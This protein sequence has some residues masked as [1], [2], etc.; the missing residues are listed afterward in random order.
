MGLVALKYEFEYLTDLK[1]TAANARYFL[2]SIRLP[3]WGYDFR[4][5]RS[6][7]SLVDTISEYLKNNKQSE[8][9]EE[10]KEE[11]V[12]PS[13]DEST[14]LE[15]E[16][17]VKYK[18]LLPNWKIVKRTEGINSIKNFKRVKRSISLWLHP[19]RNKDPSATKYMSLFNNI[20]DLIKK[21]LSK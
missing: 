20:F 17:I 16:V 5:I 13:D 7:S 21:T 9:Q 10:V 2:S 15:K 4:T 19:D 1:A 12:N 14:E 3:T 18:S 8:V 6:W 11:P